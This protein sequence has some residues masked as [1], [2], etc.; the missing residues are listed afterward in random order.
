[1]MEQES[2]YDA[3]PL[4]K[5]STH[6]M[7]TKMSAKAGINKVRENL[8][9]AMVKEYRQIDKGVLVIGNVF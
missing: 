9:S 6:V 2:K 4:N 5:L 7:F 1:M 8:V 3:D